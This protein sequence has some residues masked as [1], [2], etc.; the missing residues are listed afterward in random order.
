MLPKN[1]TRKTKLLLVRRMDGKGC[2]VIMVKCQLCT[3]DVPS[4]GERQYIDGR[5]VCADCYY[6][7]AGEIVEKNPIGRCNK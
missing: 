7:I 4:Y 2:E 5:Q 1:T 6:E 3:K